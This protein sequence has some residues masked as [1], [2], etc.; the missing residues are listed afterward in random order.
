MKIVNAAA[1]DASFL[2]HFTIAN[3][4]KGMHQNRLQAMAQNAEMADR[5]KFEQPRYPF[6]WVFCQLTILV[7]SIYL[8]GPDIAAL[9][10][11]CY[12]LLMLPLASIGLL[13]LVNISEHYQERIEALE[14]KEIELERRLELL[15]DYKGRR[16]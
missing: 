6:I 2:P 5:A 7:A 15:Q 16:R 9:I 14:A 11:V 10:G 4:G 3:R 1:A 8:F 13:H 12:L